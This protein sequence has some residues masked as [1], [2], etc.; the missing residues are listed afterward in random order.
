[1]PKSKHFCPQIRQKQQLYKPIYNLF[2]SHV[3]PRNYISL[4]PVSYIE[5]LSNLGKKLKYLCL[6]NY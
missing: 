5:T 4:K 2:I 3:L 6:Q 1:M